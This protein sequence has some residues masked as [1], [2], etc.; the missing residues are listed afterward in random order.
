M[1]G[2][3][4]WLVTLAGFRKGDFYANRTEVSKPLFLVIQ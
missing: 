2:W 1:G 4:L 3:L